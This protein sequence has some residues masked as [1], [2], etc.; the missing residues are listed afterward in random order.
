MK[1]H[2]LICAAAA[3]AFAGPAGAQ[4]TDRDREVLEQAQRDR[5]LMAQRDWEQRVQRA[6]ER[7][8]ANHGV[9]C[10]TMEG[11]QEWLLLERSRAEAVLDRVAPLPPGGSAST[12]SSTPPK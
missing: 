7:C 8:L 10:D 5:A 12:G 9:D 11:L 2:I 4:F 6:R 1:L 3:A